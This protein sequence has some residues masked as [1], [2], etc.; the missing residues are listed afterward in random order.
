MS[1]TWIS[2]YVLWWSL[3]ITTGVTWQKTIFVIVLSCESFRFDLTTTGKSTAENKR[4]ARTKL[5]VLTLMFVIVL[6]SSSASAQVML[7]VTS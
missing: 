1:L 7:L 2:I 3:L 4:S 5:C 6:S